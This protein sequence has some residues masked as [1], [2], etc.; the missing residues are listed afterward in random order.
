[1]TL[2]LGTLGD[3]FY[4]QNG[5]DPLWAYGGD[6]NDTLVG[7]DG[8]DTLVGGDGNDTLVGREGDDTLYG[9]NGNDFLVGTWAGYDP[10]PYN[11]SLLDGGNGNDTLDGA[12]G[13]ET[14]IGG[15]G[16]DLLVGHAGN[17]SLSGGDGNDSLYG[18]I[19][20]LSEEYDTLTGGAGADI[21]GL[22]IQAAGVFYSFFLLD[23][24][25]G[26]TSNDHATITDFSREQGDKIQLPGSI[27]DY[28][29]VPTSGGI[30]I[31]YNFAS[32]I[33]NLIAVVQ[34]TTELSL[35]VDYN[36]V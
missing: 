25:N 30:E 20:A 2:Y 23:P 24:G 31:Y 11:V 4:Q 29:L 35:S 17:D 32:S 1:M 8:N 36:F 22:G 27:S 13:H 16:S 9:G 33:S 26:L 7:G 3:D 14:L 5:A 15:D 12:N 18:S 21:F 10:Y 28:F 6:G 19:G 34:N